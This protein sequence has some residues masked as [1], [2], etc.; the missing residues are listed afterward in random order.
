MEINPFNISETTTT[1]V[2]TE[3]IYYAII[4]MLITYFIQGN[5]MAAKSSPSKYN[6]TC[7]QCGASFTA[8]EDI[9]KHQSQDHE[10]S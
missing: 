3:N 2:L 7:D 8:M 10:S 9:T 6:Y 4:E 1:V 5:A